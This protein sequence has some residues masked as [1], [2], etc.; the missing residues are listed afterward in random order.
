MTKGWS[1]YKCDNKKGQFRETGNIGYTIRRKIQQ[2]DNT[3]CWTP[4]DA[5]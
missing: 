1:D 5:N 2:K 3:M 4:L